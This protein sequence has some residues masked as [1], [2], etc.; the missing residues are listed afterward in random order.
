MKTVNEIFF[1]LKIDR[2]R[3][4]AFKNTGMSDHEGRHTIFA[5]F[6]SKLHKKNQ[7]SIPNKDKLMQ[8]S[9]TQWCYDLTFIGENSKTGQEGKL[10]MNRELFANIVE[11]LMSPS[12]PLLIKTPNN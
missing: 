4:T 5:Q 8:N 9:H 2:K 7:N 6:M 1:F 3:A 11:E 10:E 12:L